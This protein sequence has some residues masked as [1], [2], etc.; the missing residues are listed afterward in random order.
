MRPHR[1]RQPEPARA[2]RVQ[3]QRRCRSPSA[4]STRSRTSSSSPSRSGDIPISSATRASPRSPAGSPPPEPA[5]PTPSPSPINART[6]IF[7]TPQP[8]P[9]RAEGLLAT[10]CPMASSGR[11]RE[12]TSC[13]VVISFRGSNIRGSHEACWQELLDM[14][15]R[16][17]WSTD[18]GAGEG[19]AGGG[20]RAAEHGAD[21]D[22]GL[23]GRA[24][25]VADLLRLL[26]RNAGKCRPESEN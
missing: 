25:A 21:P 26:P 17:G 19:A 3:Q 8:T 7:I 1:H 13:A 4:A 9:R 6:P 12:A 5:S 10:V 14:S 15:T 22:G 24:L 2:P 20:R 11:R 18:D 16:A 23:G